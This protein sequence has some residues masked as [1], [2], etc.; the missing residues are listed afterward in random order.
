[1]FRKFTIAAVPAL[2]FA[3]AA[4]STNDSASQAF[5]KGGR[6][7][8]GGRQGYAQNHRGFNRDFR[9]NHRYGWGDGNYSYVEPVV[10]AP[11]VAP[12]CPTCE[13]PVAPACPTCEPVVSVVTPEYIPVTPEHVPYQRYGKYGNHFR[14]EQ[15]HGRGGHRGGRR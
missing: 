9:Q 8:N 1:M 14:H 13:A 4:F 6:G 2:M 7:G 3:L 5:A 12:A 11:I 15:F 10:E